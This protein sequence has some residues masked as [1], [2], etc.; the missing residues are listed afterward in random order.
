MTDPYASGV[1]TPEHHE[2]LVADLPAFARD[3]GIQPRWIS[4]PLADTCGPAEVEYARKFRH[5]LADG[6]VQGLCYVRTSKDVDVAPR[7]AALAGA[8]V[9][10][11][12]RARVMTVGTVLDAMAHG[13]PPEA[14]CLLIPN[15]FLPKSAGGT[16]ASWQVSA[17]FDLL[18]QRGA[19]GVQTVIYAANVAALNK[20]YGTAFGAL[21]RNSFQVVEL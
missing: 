21:V 9:R 12:V 16:I 15:F 13:E 1:L 4:M 2:R 5:H 7:M 19:A 18:S 10:N 14:T 8:L 17:L 6:E 20:E 3:A 11:F